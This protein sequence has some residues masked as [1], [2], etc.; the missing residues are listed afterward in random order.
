[1]RYNSHTPHPARLNFIEILFYFLF[2]FI[3]INPSSIMIKE[4]ISHF[5]YSAPN[6]P[7][8]YYQSL[9][10]LFNYLKMVRSIF[11]SWTAWTISCNKI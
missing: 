9:A 1:M 3:I 4:S 5:P 8:Y 6:M 10:Q 2:I 11:K 7:T